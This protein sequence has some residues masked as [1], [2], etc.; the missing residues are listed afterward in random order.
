[1]SLEGEGSPFLLPND[2]LRFFRGKL[3]EVF[4]DFGK[5]RSSVCEKLVYDFFQHRE[6]GA[7]NFF[8][9]SMRIV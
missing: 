9:C 2:S 1:M 4:S 3:S 6:E 5:N 8:L 7:S